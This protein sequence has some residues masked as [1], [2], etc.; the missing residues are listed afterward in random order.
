MSPRADGHF[1]KKAEV[2]FGEY[3]LSFAACLNL[4]E[5]VELF[6]AHGANVNAQDSRGNTNPNPYPN[7]NTNPNTNPN[8]IPIPNP[9]KVLSHD[10]EAGR[11]LVQLG[12]EQKQLRLKRQNLRA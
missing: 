8:P 4:F 3:P 11:Y 2:Y 12:P 10:V 6:A 5:L 1:F 9:N 7:P